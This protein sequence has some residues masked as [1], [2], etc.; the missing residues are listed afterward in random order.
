MFSLTS[1]QLA[2]AAAQIKMNAAQT[3]VNP[4]LITQNAQQHFSNL[5]LFGNST[6]QMTPQSPKSWAID[7]FEEVYVTNTELKPIPEEWLLELEKVQRHFP[8]AIIAGGALRDLNLGGEVKDLDIFVKDLGDGMDST[9]KMLYPTYEKLHKEEYEGIPEVG[10]C[11]EVY[12]EELDI[13][14][15]I[16][17]NKRHSTRMVLK[18]FDIDLCK[19][20]TDG[21]DYLA[22]ADALADW[23]GK[24]ITISHAQSMGQFIKSMNR[25]AKFQRKYP[26]FEIT[27]GM[28]INMKIEKDKY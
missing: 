19:F 3:L 4:P 18:N 26:D 16:I 1:A 27:L 28:G 13:P 15:Q 11:Y 21:V 10:K 23:E 14:V 17:T 22:D 5:S 20:W 2:S 7:A 24:K 25:A 6:L 12:P 9:I 8:E